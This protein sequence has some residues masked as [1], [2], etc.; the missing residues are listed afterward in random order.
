MNRS[1]GQKDEHVREAFEI[2]GRAPSPV[3]SLEQSRIEQTIDFVP[4][5]WKFIVDVGAGDGRISNILISRGVKIVG[6]D[7]SAES[8]KHFSGQKIVTDIR[9]S[10]PTVDVFD[11]AIC[12]EVLEHLT[13]DDT[14]QVLKNIRHH[15]RSGFLITV[16]ANEE[17]SVNMMSCHECGS[18]F[19][20]WG[21]LRAFNS[22]E[23]VDEMVGQVSF[24]RCF[25]PSGG[26]KGSKLLDKAKRLFG[27]TPSPESAICP[28]CG[29][30]YLKSA[31]LRGQSL[32]AV[33]VL[34]TIEYLTSFLRPRTG[35]FACRYQ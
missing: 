33:R 16:P 21:H 4:A 35:W 7:W 20:I 6:V 15:V 10:W 11:G 24:E 8:L 14:S 1:D 12:A 2:K 5:D 27:N 18:N 3:S 34:C 31:P 17:L 26:R 23:D 32:F 19:H 13:S 30:Y 22:F 29:K 28:Q 9:S 25:I